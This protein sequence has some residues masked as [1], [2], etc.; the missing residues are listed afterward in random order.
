MNWQYAFTLIISALAAAAI[1]WLGW[2]RRTAPGA[3]GLLLL[4]AALFVWSFTYAIRWLV[5]DEPAQYFWLDAT[6]LGAAVAPTAFFVFVVGYTGRGHWLTLR[7]RLL[8]AVVPVLTLVI[9]WTDPWHGLFYAGLR[10]TGTI[11]NGGPWF[12]FYVIYSYSL[13]LAVVVMLVYAFVRSANLYRR[14]N[15]LILAGVL[16]PWLGNIVSL[17][18][19]SPFPNLDITPFVFLL[20]GLLFAYGLLYFRILDVMPIARD[21]L[22]ENMRDGVIVLDAQQRIVDVNPAAREM[23]GWPTARIGES[24]APALQR[25]PD[26]GGLLTSREESRREVCSAQA[27][28]S[29]LDARVTPLFDAKQRLTG[30]LITL[31]DITAQK[32]VTAELAEARDVAQAA[33]RAK[34][35]FLANMSHELRTPLSAIL[36]FSELMI[37][38]PALSPAQQEYLTFINHSGEHLLGLINGVLDMAKVEAGRVTLTAQSFDLLRLLDDLVEMFHMR[39]AA[40]GV[41]LR[42]E[43]DPSTPQWIV[44]D[45]GK[46]RQVLINLLGNAVKFTGAGSVTLSVQCVAQ[47]APGLCFTVADTGVGIAPEDIELIFEP[48]I[49]ATNGHAAQQ[50]TGLGLAISREYVRLM[51]GEL[52]ATSPGVPGLGSRF[53][54]TIPLTAA[55]IPG[56]APAPAPQQALCLAP[57]QPHYRLL[58]VEDH[59]AT[60]ELLT[61]MLRSLGFEVRSAQNGQEGLEVAATWQPH[62]VWTDVRMPVMNGREL[63]RRLKASAQRDAPVIIAVSASVL[64]E[65]RAQVLAD[66][67]DDFVHKPFRQEEI[68][69][70][71]V[72]HLG[73]Q[74]VYAPAEAP[75]SG[76]LHIAPAWAAA[77]PAWRRQVQEAAAT[78]DA[79]RL[80]QLATSVAAE[81]PELAAA[82]RRQIDAFDYPAILAAVEEHQ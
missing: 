81:Q 22:V 57:G 15:G 48:F 11:L 53:T 17:A 36:G 2:R 35:D 74:M 77:P 29:T 14:Q 33:N 1:V 21:K 47:P 61:T 26:L 24:I 60:R 43:R 20:S 40:H 66:G 63:A 6:Y 46:L 73:V 38:D 31:H 27:P 62:L 49:Q 67:C 25:W 42:L 72:K 19:L 78:A 10:T 12:W 13:M 50:G 32:R 69:A 41:A 56:D 55:P 76:P 54:F 16:L 71:L 8:L 70:R 52:T 30:R 79:P 3:G 82:L 34:S 39:T 5:S 44:A 75:A 37:R 7:N 68:V 23:A 18:G 28:V 58:V 64:P 45:M 80:H 9:L 51:G 65:E 59:P 4:M